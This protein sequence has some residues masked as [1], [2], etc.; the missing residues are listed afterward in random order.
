MPCT[1]C[2]K[3]LWSLTCTVGRV[4][5]SSRSGKLILA[6]YLNAVNSRYSATPFTEICGVIS[7]ISVNWN[8]VTSKTYKVELILPKVLITTF[9]RSNSVQHLQIIFAFSFINQSVRIRKILKSDHKLR[10][11][12]L[13]VCLSV[14]HW[15]IVKKFDICVIFLNLS[16][17]FKFHLI[18][19]E[20][21]VLYMKT[22]WQLWSNL[23]ELF[24]EWEIFQ[25]KL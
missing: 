4:N 22:Y 23:A 19:E 3:C 2:I 1:L 13:C 21:Q 20:Y 5:I 15:R 6:P 14:Y 11:I 24:L 10:Y 17:K 25:T 16:R 18:L 12:C 7:R 9:K 8:I